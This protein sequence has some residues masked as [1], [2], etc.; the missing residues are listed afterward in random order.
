MTIVIGGTR[1]VVTPR[2]P[3]DIVLSAKA[4]VVNAI[5][6]GKMPRKTTQPMSA[7]EAA[8]HV[9]EELAGERQAG[10]RADRAGQPGDLDGGQAGH[11]RLL[12]D[13]A[14][15][16]HDR[17]QEAQHDAGHAAVAV[18]AGGGRDEDD[19]ARRRGPARSRGTP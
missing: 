8:P 1:Y 19:T 2:L 15:G 4:N 13:Q 3:A 14:D 12:Q 10:D 11:E 6:V 9:V 7:P 17:G 16:V 5:A 18:L